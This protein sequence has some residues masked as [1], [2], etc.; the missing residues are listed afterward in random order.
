M[1]RAQVAIL[2]DTVCIVSS[3]SVWTFI[4]Q[5][6]TTTRVITVFTHTLCV[7]RHTCMWALRNIPLLFNLITYKFPLT[8]SLAQTG[9]LCSAL[10]LGNALGFITDR[11]LTFDYFC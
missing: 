9:H 1:V 7:E 5:F 10:V 6:L 8:V 3:L 2:A 4:G 11:S